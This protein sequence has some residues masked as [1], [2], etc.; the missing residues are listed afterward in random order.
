[1]LISH[2]RADVKFSDTAC[3]CSMMVQP[4]TEPGIQWHIDAVFIATNYM[5]RPPQ[6]IGIAIGQFNGNSVGLAG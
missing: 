5:T 2:A 1:M 3:S 6:K 4:W